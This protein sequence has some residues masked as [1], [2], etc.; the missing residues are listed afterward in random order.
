M[1]AARR[2]VTHIHD[3]RLAQGNTLVRLPANAPL[4]VDGSKKL[5]SMC[6]ASPRRHSRLV[7]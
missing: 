1:R 4:V 3:A 6:G 2:L 7:R 5:V